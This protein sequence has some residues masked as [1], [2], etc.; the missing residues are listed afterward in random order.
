M[1]SQLCR[2]GI[3]V[4]LLGNPSYASIARAAKYTFRKKQRSAVPRL[5]VEP[6]LFALALYMLAH[7]VGLADLWVGLDIIIRRLRI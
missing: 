7:G 1:Y 2:Y 6:L 4:S 3:L 5:F